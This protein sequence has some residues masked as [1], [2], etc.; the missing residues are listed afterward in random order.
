MGDGGEDIS[1]SLEDNH[2]EQSMTDSGGEHPSS[3]IDAF[4]DNLKIFIIGGIVYPSTHTRRRFVMD[5][6]TVPPFLLPANRNHTIYNT[7]FLKNTRFTDAKV[8]E[9]SQQLLMQELELENIKMEDLKKIKAKELTKILFSIGFEK[10]QVSKLKTNMAKREAIMN[11]YQSIVSGYSQCHSTGNRKKASGGWYNESCVH[12]TIVASKMLFCSESVRDVMDIKLSKKLNS[13]T[14]ILDTPCT[15]A[16]HLLTRD[17]FVAKLWFEGN[18]GCF[19]KP[20]LNKAP[21]VISIPKL[22][23]ETNQKQSFEIPDLSSLQL[24]S[25]PKTKNTRKYFVGDRFHE[26]NYPHKSELCRFHDIDLVPELKGAKTSGQEN[27][28]FVRNWRRLRST[29]TQNAETHLFYNVV[30]MDRAHNR[31]IVAR[32]SKIQRGP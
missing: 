13:P 20:S 28:N 22:E 3:Y 10:T 16:S 21:S 23:L 15:A 26:A 4:L 8:I 11:L 1:C 30:V 12:G 31:R 24:H 9:G 2:L 17:P 18:R 32:S 29:C 6:S 7:E 25:H 19:E 5:M 14:N 27:L